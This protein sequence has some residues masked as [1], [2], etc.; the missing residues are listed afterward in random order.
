MGG[1]T[2]E[3]KLRAVRMC[4]EDDALSWYR[5][6]RVRNL[7]VSW[8]QMK[9]RVLEKF[10]STEDLTPGERLL[11][12]RQHDTMGQ[13]CK[14]FIAF[15]IKCTRGSRTRVG[16]G[17]KPKIRVWVKMF[18]PHIL[19]KMMSLAKKVEDWSGDAPSE[20]LSEGTMMTTKMGGERFT[21]R[22]N[23][24]PAGGVNSSFS[25]ITYCQEKQTTPS[26]FSGDKTL[27]TATKAGETRRA[28]YRRLT[29][30]EANERRSKGLCFRCDERFHV[31]H[32][33]RLKELQVLMVSEGQEGNDL[34]D[35][36]E[37]VFSD[38]M[39]ECAVLSRSSANGISSP[40]TMKMRGMIQNVE[41]KVLIDGASHN[42][43]SSSLA[44]QLGIQT[45]STLEYGVKM[46][47]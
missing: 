6:E 23:P 40:R 34:G 42:F 32:K 4:F 39:A 11:L 5:W 44:R 31:G 45:Q 17:L 13:F 25:K 8:E 12:L 43:L 3:E 38:A 35:E 41:V 16:D 18:E 29:D 46:G 14:N 15:S 21:P 22:G 20:T 9:F 7:F 27:N 1:F 30:V 10:S 33:C 26:R 36:T 28:P 2:E 47:T 37:E 24:L 19:K